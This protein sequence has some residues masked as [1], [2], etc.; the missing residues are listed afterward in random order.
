MLRT[1]TLVLVHVK[2]RPRQIVTASTWTSST[3][4]FG[5]GTTGTAA[6]CPRFVQVLRDPSSEATGSSEHSCERRTIDVAAAH[7][8]DDAFAGEPIPQ[9]DGSHQRRGAGALS[10]V[11][12]RPQRQPHAFGELVF[13]Q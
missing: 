4:V 11:V 12:R 1:W 7:H 13:A 8:A 10:E 3:S 2:R 6:R 9:L 5:V